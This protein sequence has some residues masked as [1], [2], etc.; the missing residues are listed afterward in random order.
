MSIAQV[1]ECIFNHLSYLYERKFADLP[2]ERMQRRQIQQAVRSVY[3]NQELQAEYKC[4]CIHACPMCNYDNVDVSNPSLYYI[5]TL[6]GKIKAS[7]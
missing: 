3:D 6:A 1:F 2:H 5:F 7:Q 4:A